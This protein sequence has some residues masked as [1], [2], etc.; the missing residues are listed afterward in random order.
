MAPPKV[1]FLTKMFHPN[2]AHAPADQV[3]TSAI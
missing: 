2:S 3:N 1:R